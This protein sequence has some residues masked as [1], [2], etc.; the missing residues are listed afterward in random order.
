[1]CN[2]EQTVWLARQKHDHGLTV[3]VWVI[4]NIKSEKFV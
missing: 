1:M 2:K 4:I 3:K